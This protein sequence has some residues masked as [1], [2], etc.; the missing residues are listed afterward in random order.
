MESTTIG[1]SPL[2]NFQQDALEAA[3]R[4]LSK[5][6]EETSN[7]K[8]LLDVNANDLKLLKNYFVQ[9]AQWK[10]K[11]S[12]G[13][14]EIE[15]KLNEAI[16][17]GRLFIK[18]EDIQAMYYFLGKV[19]GKGKHIDNDMFEGKPETYLRILKAI[20]AGIKR[21]DE[22]VERIK[23]AEFIVEAR[24]QGIEPDASLLTDQPKL[25]VVTDR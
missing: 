8:F 7:K 21:I 23:K 11:E 20:D 2:S 12:L 22:D 10:F 1:N 5:L 16:K 4:E 19:E 13:I 17:E 3:E 24:R 18:A 14:I 6:H 15:K 9:H 25:E